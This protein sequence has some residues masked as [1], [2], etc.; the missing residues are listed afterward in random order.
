M[1]YISLV[2]LG[3]DDLSRAIEFYERLG[4]RRSSASVEGTVAFLLGGPVVL[5]LWGR[6]DLAADA[7]L[8]LPTSTEGDAVALAMNVG[9]AE[10]VDQVIASAGDAG[11][12]IPRGGEGTDWGGYSGYFM[13]PDGHL[14]EV[15]H[16]P[17]WEL[18][19]DGRIALPDSG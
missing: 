13:D 17:F 1:P 12:T 16:N 9:S 3:V 10:E 7:K 6:E 2:T 15:A 14:W 18:L 19:E 11:A 8:S 4:W 5:A